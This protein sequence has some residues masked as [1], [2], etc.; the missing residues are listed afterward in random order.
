VSERINR[1]LYILASL[2]EDHEPRVVVIAAMK[3]YFYFVVVVVVS[4]S[5]CFEAAA[6][7]SR[8]PK[9]ATTSATTST[10][11][12]RQRQSSIR[13]QQNLRSVSRLALTPPTKSTDRR[14]VGPVKGSSKEGTEEALLLGF[15]KKSVA[16]PL[17][18]V[19]ISQFV[20]FVGVGAV[21]PSI[22]LYGKEI[23]LSS[24]ANGVV[25]SAPA[26]ALLLGAKRGGTYA[27]VARKPAML[28]GMA[29]IAVS[30]VGTAFANSLLT[31]FVAR[32]GLG[33]GR[34]V[35]EAGERG[36][37][38]DLA[39][40]VP[41]LRG[42]ALAAQQAVV[43]LGIA[44][45]APLGGVVVERYG[46]RASFLCVSVAAI[47]ALV[48]YLFLPET[49][50]SALL[51]AEKKAAKAERSS[52][53]EYSEKDKTEFI[54]AAFLGPSESVDIPDSAEYNGGADWK[55]LL[56]TNQWRG[57][58]LCQSGASF[59]FAAKV[60]S[61]P[62]LASSVLPGGAAGAGALVSAAG[63]SGLVGAPIGGWLTDRTGSK[64]TAILSGLVS[65]TGLILIPLALSLDDVASGVLRI[66]GG[67]EL[68][69]NALAFS[70]VVIAWSIG[71]A[72]QGPAM[73]AYAQELA[74]D[75]SEATAMALPRAAGDG[76]YIVAPFLLGLATDSFLDLPGI[77]CAAAG[78]ATALGVIA[79]ATSGGYSSDI[80]PAKN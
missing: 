74:P 19:L 17:G 37:L 78:A 20:L 4:A 10:S 30:D 76:T 35:S 64:S 39:S 55:D 65:A 73:T 24:A 50:P 22:P 31:L 12:T 6:S 54:E 77:E 33:A 57:L 67:A 60:A 66:A 63:L 23:G 9:W 44:I 61:I 42:R 11:G 13:R 25:I 7:F 8:H 34:C 28:L 75:G 48:M 43:A 18:L 3:R 38:A 56:A 52:A 14:T 70:A 27:D 62:I 29:V 49:K 59:G 5:L 45:G 15:P 1:L 41:E 58:A 47:V 2:V 40:R 26:V 80:G 69:T 21:I 32:L 71:A 53:S 72:A 51:A 36:M 68:H 79:L 46:P 16:I